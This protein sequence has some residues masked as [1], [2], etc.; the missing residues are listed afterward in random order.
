[1]EN[2]AKN[3]HV[4]YIHRESNCPLKSLVARAPSA[5]FSSEKDITTMPTTTTT[6]ITTTTTTTTTA[7]KPTILMVC[8]WWESK[9]GGVGWRATLTLLLRLLYSCSIHCPP[10]SLVH[11]MPMPPKPSNS[12]EKKGLP[13]YTRTCTP[14]PPSCRYVMH[15]CMYVCVHTMCMGHDSR[16]WDS[17]CPCQLAHR[18]WRGSSEKTPQQD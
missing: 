17:W 11:S 2:E 8:T 14:C 7:A 15:A 1:M 12:M 9:K 5:L 18:G 3:A 10:S 6:P 4:P 16:A 13:Y